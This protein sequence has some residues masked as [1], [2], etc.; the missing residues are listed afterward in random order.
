MMRGG[1]LSIETLQKRIK[2]AEEELKTVTNSKRR[3][4]VKRKL[5]LNINRLTLKVATPR[6]MNKTAETTAV[7]NVAANEE[8]DELSKLFSK[9]MK[10][11]SDLLAL[12]KKVLE[13]YEKQSN[14]GNVYEI[15]EIITILRK[16]GLTNEDLVDL[17]PTFTKIIS[18][19]KGPSQGKMTQ[20]FEL[21]EKI[22]MN[23]TLIINGKKVVSLRNA[24][25]DDKDS[26]TADI[27]YIFEDNS[28]L[29]QSITGGKIKKDKTITKCLSN[30]TCTRY[31][32][33]DEDIIIFKKI[34]KKAV[35]EYKKEMTDKYGA[36]ETKWPSRI[37]TKAATNATEKVAQ[38]VVERF[39]TLSNEKKVDIM[40]DILY[41]K[42]GKKPANIL[43]VVDT[44]LKNIRR[45]EIKSVKATDK[46]TP[47]FKQDKF[48]IEMYINDDKVASTQVKFNN[49]VYHKGKTSSLISSWNAYAYINK[50][51]D[52]E[53]FTF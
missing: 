10:V 35:E 48:N 2:N 18:I 34:G 29:G 26:Y 49:G 52:L 25:Q 4:A 27:I 11:T 46:W 1:V 6:K 13:P 17:K 21:C 36:D 32:C 40:E 16:M 3:T 24:T 14:T 15:Y 30:P 44:D 31:G 7:K 38:K 39:N 45:F 19:T 23:N 53:E 42:E 9:T 20:M 5:K 37:V 28:Q 33:I 50:L 12:A 51:F 41:L 47:S 43:C 8:E 22:P